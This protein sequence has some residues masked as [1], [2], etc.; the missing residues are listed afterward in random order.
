MAEYEPVDTSKE[1]GI[2]VT[3]P[4]DPP[5]RLREQ[6]P[7][8][9][10]L[11][12][13]AVRRQHLLHRLGSG[14]RTPL[15]L[16]S[17]PAGSGK[18]TLLAQYASERSCPVAWI[19]LSSRE[20]DPEHFWSTVCAGVCDA[21]AQCGLTV[22]AE[23]V[24]A[25]AHRLDDLIGVL[26]NALSTGNE[27][28]TIILDDFQRVNSSA[29]QSELASWI[30]SLPPTVLLFI[31]TRVDPEL[32]LARLRSAGRLT[33]IR[34][35]D[36]ALT[37]EETRDF[38]H[39]VIGPSLARRDADVVYARTEGWAAGV[40]LAS[41]ALSTSADDRS[42]VA[43][44]FGG[45]HPFLLDYFVDEVLAELPDEVVDFLLSTSIAQSLCASLCDAITG[46]SR[47]GAILHRLRRENLFLVSLDH[48]SRWYRYH[49][50]FADALQRRLEDKGADTIRDLHRRAAE[51]Y[52]QRGLTRDGIHHALSAGAHHTVADA[53]E[54]QANELLW[55]RGDIAELLGWL[56]AL[57]RE[58]VTARPR[59]LLA[60]AWALAL[61]GQLSTIERPL[62]LMERSLHL[63]TIGDVR[64]DVAHLTPVG[65]PMLP[66]QQD[67]GTVASRPMSDE[68]LL[69]EIAAVRA[70]AA[71]LQIDTT[72]L[73]S[74]SIE[75]ITH[76]PENQFLQ[77]IVA[78]S[79]GRAFDLGADVNSAIAAYAEA[80]VLGGRIEN[81]YVQAVP[82]SRLAELWA[83]Q[84]ELH[85][86][87]DLHRR[88]LQDADREPDRQA[89]VGA[90]AHVGLG[91]L[92]YEW[93]DLEAASRH[94]EEGVRRA[95][96]W[97]H[98]ETLKGAY[99]GLARI[100]FVEGA[101]DD[102][103]E[104]LREAEDV[105]QHSNAPRSVAWVHAMQARL[106]LAHGDI[107]NA[108]RWA[109]LSPLHADRDPM[110]A[111]TGEYATLVRL[112]L[113]QRKFDDAL[114]LLTRL[115][116]VAASQHRV[117]LSIELLVLQALAR[118]ATG[119][120]RAA[121]LA[122]RKAIS[123]AAPEGYL[124][125]FLDEGPGVHAILRRGVLDNTMPPYLHLVLEAFNV[126]QIDEAPS[127][128]Q[129]AALSRRELEI[130]HHIA[131]GESNGEIA[132]G[133]GLSL[134]TV[135]RHVSNIFGKIGV[136]SRT[137]AVARARQRGLL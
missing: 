38:L 7:A 34:G 28:L 130:L 14:Q 105:A 43:S 85:S 106:Y 17:G 65:R 16:V 99:F 103:F 21:C 80:S 136:G 6:V 111:F 29:T 125:T 61:T 5:G 90:M 83:V 19:T 70:V 22:P 77:S 46:M 109:Q 134:A 115:F 133:L 122:L 52:L 92:H 123:L 35:D 51:W 113:A 88:V 36:L 44:A 126:P 87:A 53:I 32:P 69:G 95:T 66:L 119:D 121:L 50:G 98:L 23:P 24:L 102:A 137:Q 76:A 54:R 107:P 37:A 101:V 48:Q 89:A 114:T 56:D 67:V 131:A 25:S 110:H 73:A 68:A 10:R 39:H 1:A 55:E 60:H 84:G 33:E 27:Y 124:R 42:S 41:I 71:G 82:P 15:T 45:T 57:P 135:K 128:V 104:L 116:D 75:A 13:D 91:S 81:R 94:F 20:N 100:R 9:P 3:R 8:V 58:V 132:E 64:D 118:S 78:L 4:F 11:P 59:L 74:W 62:R 31:G 18:T 97:G 79:R 49:H 117:G 120:S 26:D 93:N 127:A 96:R 40:R 12:N 129:G 86:A 47:S 63:S 2:M 108:A 112:Q 72:Q 30:D